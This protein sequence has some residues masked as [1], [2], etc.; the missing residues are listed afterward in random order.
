MTVLVENLGRGGTGGGP[1]PVPPSI[2]LE[3]AENFRRPLDPAAPPFACGSWGPNWA[4]TWLNTSNPA[5]PI[6]PSITV[7]GQGQ[8]NAA[9]PTDA[10]TAAYALRTA[11]IGAF[12]LNHFCELRM[13]EKPASDDWNV[14]LMTNFLGA[15]GVPDYVPGCQTRPGF[16]FL[17]LGP[18]PD[19]NNIS[20]ELGF[21]WM[22]TQVDL[23]PDMEETI[24][25]VLPDT[26]LN[27]LCR[28]ESR[29]TD[30]GS[31]N[32]RVMLNGIEVANTNS[33]A[34]GQGMPAIG[35]QMINDNPLV[36]V[37]D[38]RGGWLP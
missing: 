26:P 21:R 24:I 22:F 35:C 32:L 29:V 34:L 38:Y 10:F 1:G 16:F 2:Y 37:D 33:F 9:A 17:K 8:F 6:I 27:S 14:F 18:A 28:I 19:P 30:V 12:I 5:A 7:D 25:Q 20:V 15:S 31:W 36:R 23:I 13:R 4:V 3:F 11:W